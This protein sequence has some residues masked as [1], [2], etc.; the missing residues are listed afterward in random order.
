MRVFWVASM[1]TWWVAVGLTG[2]GGGSASTTDA[3]AISP[4]A[5]ASAPAPLAA[6][7]ILRQNIRAG[8]SDA[9]V[10]NVLDDLPW[11]PPSVWQPGFAYVQG[12]VVRGLE[13]DES[14]QYIAMTA[15]GPSSTVGPG[16]SGA[17]DGPIQ[18]GGVTWYYDGEV[19]LPRADPGQ[20]T[21]R[22]GR[23]SD[24]LKDW[25]GFQTVTPSLE[26]PVGQFGG[27]I[28]ALDPGMPVPVVTVFGGNGG[29]QARPIYQAPA[30]ASLMFS[31]D[32]D[33][34]LL[35]SFNAIYPRQRMVIE[36]NG[37]R[38]SDGQVSIPADTALINP[39]GFEIDFSQTSL[40][41]LA[42][43][44]RIR[45]T[46]GFAITNYRLI[47]EAGSRIWV[48]PSP[49]HWKLAVE[50]DSLT[51]GGYNTPYQPGQ[52]WVTQMGQL[53]G[54]DDVSNLAQGGTGFISDNGGRKT[55]YEQRVERL[56]SLQAD[57]YLIAGNHNDSSYPRE[58]QIGAALSYL[59]RLRALQPDAVIVV[60][61]NN[62]LQGESTVAGPI[63]E[64]EKNLR[65]AFDLWADPNAL[66]L[67]ISTDPGG[68]W[69]TGSGAV[70]HPMGDGNMDH[71]YITRD[72]HPL[73]RGVDYFARRYARALAGLFQ[74]P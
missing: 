19:R 7:A 39:G 66:F 38:L 40:K 64:A 32:S 9:A 4:Q 65:T 60:A 61:G 30:T 1:C 54:C 57:V 35:Q 25:P 45:T 16:P 49:H 55:R 18:D 22:W 3:P 34:V 72:G 68:P 62:P 69:I 42:K 53:I 33:R 23:P 36:V 28:V 20:A 6:D 31:T 70:D 37:R 59:R 48:E 27:G 15:S 2:C 11:G 58:Q 47:T 12:D 13:G 43:Q 8:M 74:S 5:G 17:G 73:Q 52:D 67:P 29:T 56:A 14:H 63:V 71:F 50:G 10:H 41:G 26:A 21:V 44:I 51:Q 24:L 46:E